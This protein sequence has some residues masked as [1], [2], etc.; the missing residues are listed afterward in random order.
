MLGKWTHVK[1]KRRGGRAGRLWEDVLLFFYRSL[2]LIAICSELPHSIGGKV[3]FIRH[4]GRGLWV[5]WWRLLN[6]LVVHFGL[7]NMSECKKPPCLLR[8]HWMLCVHSYSPSTTINNIHVSIYFF[9]LN[10]REDMVSFLS[11]R[12]HGGHGKR[13]LVSFSTAIWRLLLLY[14]PLW[15][16]WLCVSASMN[17][18]FWFEWNF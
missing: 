8:S 15:H 18:W 17:C 5:C 9:L 6:G 10:L 2:Y 4:K 1:G 11:H 14:H 3:S 12:I 7:W 16:D 13:I